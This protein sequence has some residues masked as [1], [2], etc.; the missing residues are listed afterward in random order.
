MILVS[1]H[2]CSLDPLNHGLQNGDD[3]S[4]SFLLHLLIGILSIKNLLSWSI[5]ISWNS[6]CVSKTGKRLIFFLLSIFWVMIWGPKNLP[7]QSMSFSFLSIIKNLQIFLYLFQSIAVN[8]LLDAQFF[9]STVCFLQDTSSLWYHSYFLA[10]D[11]VSLFCPCPSPDLKINHFPKENWF[12]FLKTI[13]FLQFLPLSGCIIFYHGCKPSILF[14]F[15]KC[16]SSG[17]F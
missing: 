6:N 3:L 7:W 16:F 12:F 2:V 17:C 5:W 4:P 1:L 14:F 11:T 15:L 10:Q 13:H 9:L 8:I